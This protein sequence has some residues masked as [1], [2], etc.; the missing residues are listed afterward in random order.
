MVLSS[1]SLS[2]HNVLCQSVCNTQLLLFLSFIHE[3]ILW[4]CVY[5]STHIFSD[6]SSFF[7]GESLVS[8]LS[9][10]SQLA[11]LWVSSGFSYLCLSSHLSSAEITLA[12]NVGAEDWLKSLGLCNN[13]IY[14]L[15]HLPNFCIRFLG[16]GCECFFN[17]TAVPPEQESS[18][19]ASDPNTEEVLREHLW[20]Q[21]SGLNCFFSYPTVQWLIEDSK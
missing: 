5:A 10:I 21:N 16:H 8:L 3:S 18:A 1:G 19:P 6:V 12:S 11:G 15:S 17:K 9:C 14:L 4:V 13:W 2:K 7:W 20:G